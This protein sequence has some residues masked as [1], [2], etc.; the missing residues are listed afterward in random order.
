MVLGIPVG[1]LPDICGEL[2]ERDERFRRGIES[3]VTVQTQ[4]FQLW[5]HKTAAELGWDH[6]ENSV[7]GCYVEPL[8]T[9]CDMTH[10]IGRESWPQAGGARTIGYFCGV[11]DEQA[12]ETPAQTAERA[13][14]AESARRAHMYRM[15]LA[16][17]KARRLRKQVAELEAQLAGDDDPEVLEE[18]AALFDG[19]APA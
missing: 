7:A 2:M 12:G 9:Y 11:I 10:L 4:A 19:E 18:A 17:H 5:S 6:D 3:A 1:A 14:R 16:S 15:A 13:K 8:D